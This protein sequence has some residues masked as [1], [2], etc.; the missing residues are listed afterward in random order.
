MTVEQIIHRALNTGR[1]S[2]S[3]MSKLLYLSQIQTLSGE[4]LLHEFLTSLRQGQV[5]LQITTPR[6][7]SLLIMPRR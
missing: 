6:T 5:Q 2:Q 4:E 1:I 7:R 3:D